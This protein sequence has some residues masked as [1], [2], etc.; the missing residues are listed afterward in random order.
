MHENE[1]A[2]SGTAIAM[3]HVAV[4]RGVTVGASVLLRHSG[5]KLREGEHV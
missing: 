5:Y 4:A 3:E 2:Q 1:K